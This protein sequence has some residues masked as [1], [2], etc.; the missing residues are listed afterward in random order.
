METFKLEDPVVLGLKIPDKSRVLF[1]QEHTGRVTLDLSGIPGPLPAVAVDTHK[2]Y[3][4]IDLGTLT[5][6]DA[7]WDAPYESDWA[8]AVGDFRE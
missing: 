1:Y 8:V 2:E 4:E 5:A 7:G 6:G 3:K